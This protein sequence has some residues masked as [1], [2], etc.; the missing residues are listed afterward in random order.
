MNYFFSRLTPESL[1]YQWLLY[2]RW[3]PRAGIIVFLGWGGL[4]A[5]DRDPPFKLLDYWTSQ[6]RPGGV[7]V[8]RARVQRALERDCSVTFSRYLFDRFGARHEG[9]GPQVMTPRALRNM[10]A[11]APGELNVQMTIP[12]GFPPGPA[13][14]TTV[15]EYRCNALQDV[16]RPIGVEMQIPFEV[17]SQ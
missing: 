13:V 2:W 11:M 3:I 1:L 6:P 16:L 9:G 12:V 17:L 15:L 4:M 8:V 5:L 10:D 14:M 7:L